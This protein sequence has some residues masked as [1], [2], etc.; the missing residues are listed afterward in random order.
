MLPDTVI[1]AVT[2]IVT[3][4]VVDVVVI[5]TGVGIGIETGVNV[6]AGPRICY[7]GFFGLESFSSWGSTN[8]GTMGLSILVVLCCFF[9]SSMIF[10]TASGGFA[11]GWHSLLGAGSAFV[12]FLLTLLDELSFPSMLKLLLCLTILA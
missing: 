10:L 12:V 9:S 3:G 11:P 8:F 1:G 6:E 4:F 7:M 5:G 2:G